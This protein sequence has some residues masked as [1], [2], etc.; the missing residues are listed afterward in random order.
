MNA[1][2]YAVCLGVLQNGQ[3]CRK[4]IGPS[5]F[6]SPEKKKINVVVIKV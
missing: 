1:S 6:I 2:E 4:A 3:A 5:S